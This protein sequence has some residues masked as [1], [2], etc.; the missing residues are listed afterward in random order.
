MCTRWC[1]VVDH[2][3]QSVAVVN[4]AVLCS[5]CPLELVQLSLAVGLLF[6]GDV[7]HVNFFMGLVV[8]PALHLLVNCHHSVAPVWEYKTLEI[9][10]GNDFSSIDSLVRDVYWW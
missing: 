5:A 2:L 8:G 4:T 3:G 7:A 1:K 9:V 6:S 10:L